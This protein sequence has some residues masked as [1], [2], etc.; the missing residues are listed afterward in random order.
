VTT[1]LLAFFF[2]LRIIRVPA[3]E[4]YLHSGP[5]KALQSLVAVSMARLVGS[6]WPNAGRIHELVHA[7]HLSIYL[8]QSQLGTTN[9]MGGTRV[10][11]VVSGPPVPA[12]T[13]SG[14]HLGTNKEP[15]VCSLKCKACVLPSDEAHPPSE[16]ERRCLLNHKWY[17][18]FCSGWGGGTRN[19]LLHPTSFL[20]TVTSR[21]QTLATTM[22]VT[23][24]GWGATFPGLRWVG[25]EDTGC[26]GLITNRRQ[27]YHH[28]YN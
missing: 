15:W 23:W 17:F 11:S 20:L 9:E 3:S 10:S 28:W 22:K 21:G 5:G 8:T 16:R 7:V 25:V 1:L 6:A 13:A 18:D 24:K 27:V 19:W 2:L 26:C 4:G 14:S 12:P